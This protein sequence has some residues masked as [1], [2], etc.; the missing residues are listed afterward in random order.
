MS[1]MFGYD[2]SV[3]LFFRLAAPLNRA[4][5]ARPLQ[6]LVEVSALCLDGVDVQIRNL[7]RAGHY[8]EHHP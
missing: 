7:S 8:A 4:R 6:G 2:G 3:T 5:T 1:T